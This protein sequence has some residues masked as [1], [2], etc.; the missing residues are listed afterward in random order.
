MAL[1]TRIDIEDETN[2]DRADAT[3]IHENNKESHGEE[4]NEC[5]NMTAEMT[6]KELTPWE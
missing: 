2:A 4:Y 5:E 1:D 6:S 3:N